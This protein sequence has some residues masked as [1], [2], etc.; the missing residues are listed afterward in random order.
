MKY[1]ID[2]AKN[3]YD[4]EE[5]LKYV[6]FW[7][8]TPTKD[9]SITKTCLSQWWEQPF[10]AEGIL[11]PSAEHWMMAGKAK[12]FG[13]EEILHKIQQTASPAEAK[14]LGRAV[15]NFEQNAWEE[16][17]YEIVKEGNLLKFG[18]N[19]DLKT[20]L[21]NTQE[22]V[23][24]EASPYDPIWGIG[25]KQDASNIENPHTWQGLNLLGFAL[26]EVREMLR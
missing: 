24:V 7:G 25:L 18:Q 13:D 4:A 3:K 9:G 14:K 22:R 21:V 16:A 19:D 15:R 11:Y 12:L 10:S 17:R 6:F 8:H 1:H 20:Y 23:L 26:M 5:R 2:W